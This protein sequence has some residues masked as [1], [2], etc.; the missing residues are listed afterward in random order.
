MVLGSYKLHEV[1]R[2]DPCSDEF[3]PFKGEVDICP[4]STAQRKEYPAGDRAAWVEAFERDLVAGRF[5]Q[6]AVGLIDAEAPMVG[7]YVA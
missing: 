5:G 4:F 6:A 2:T 3:Y 7:A 1:D